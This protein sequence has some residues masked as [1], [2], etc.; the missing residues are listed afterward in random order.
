[1][2]PSIPRVGFGAEQTKS[3]GR[4]LAA[5]NMR[6]MSATLAVLAVQLAGCAENTLII[7]ATNMPG[8]LWIA[9]NAAELHGALFCDQSLTVEQRSAR[10][11]TR[12]SGTSVELHHRCVK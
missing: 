8:A 10:V 1:M 7:R 4:A 5:D 9:R 3:Q 2:L 12:N 6:I 11:A